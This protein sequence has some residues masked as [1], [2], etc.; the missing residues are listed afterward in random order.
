MARPD[1]VIIRSEEIELSDNAPDQLG[2]WPAHPFTDPPRGDDGEYVTAHF[3]RRNWYA[4]WGYPAAAAEEPHEEMVGD[5][6]VVIGGEEVWVQFHTSLAEAASYVRGGKGGY[7]SLFRM[8]PNHKLMA[9]LQ[10]RTPWAD[11][12]PRT[13]QGYRGRLRQQGHIY[14]PELQA[15][16]HRWAPNLLWL[17]RHKDRDGRLAPPPPEYLWASLWPQPRT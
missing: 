1:K 8:Q 9:A 7:P 4:M 6:V 3:L 15:Q 5:E 12:S 11:L 17:R 14:S 16:W 13:L 2:P 10:R